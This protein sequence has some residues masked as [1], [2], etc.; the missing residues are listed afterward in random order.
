MLRPLKGHIPLLVLLL[1]VLLLTVL[2]AVLGQRSLKREAGLLLEVKRRQAD[3]LVRA[4][5]SASRLDMVFPDPEHRPLRDFLIDAG[6]AE[7]ILYAALYDGEGRFLLA[8]PGF[9]PDRQGMAPA[10]LS[11]F[12]GGQQRAERLYQEQGTGRVFVTVSR[13]APFDAPWVRLR[14]LGLPTV[15]GVTRGPETLAEA[16]RFR[17]ALIGMGT[18]DL[19]FS[20]REARRQVLLNGALLLLLGT[21]GFLFLILV[22][23][24]HAVRRALAQV[25][26]YSVDLVEGMSEGLV[27][28]DPGGVVRT[29]NPAA[30]R[31]LGI[32]AREAAGK[33]LR[34]LF[35]GEEWEELARAMTEG[36]S[37]FDREMSSP[38]TEGRPLSVSLSALKGEAGRGSVLFIRDLEMVRQLQ[39]EV[40]RSER[41][42]ALGRMVAGMAHEVR[43]P[44]NA[45]RGFTQHLSSRF[46]PGTSEARAAEVII[47]E[48]DRLNRV[49]TELLDFSRAK[50]VRKERLDLNDVARAAAALVE[51]EAAAA[52]VKLM[53][54]LTI[55]PL[56]VEAD[57]DS[58]K[59]VL[60]NLLLNGI[61]AMP[62][63]GILTV[64]TGMGEEGPAVTVSDT[65]PGIP[66]SDRERIFEPFFTTRARGT[67][68]GLALVHRI[69]QDHGGEVRVS[70]AEGKGSSFTVRLPRPSAPRKEGDA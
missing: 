63:G 69:V 18:A 21:V 44:L 59:Q 51:R 19:D 68:L 45:I 2:L 26:Q 64:G 35:P 6:G 29:V 31:L 32:T 55:A 54:D 52:G 41:L 14:L 40:R 28:A 37:W 8:S 25:R 34:A 60:L 47:R 67:G 20:L 5:T 3:L 48:V 46:S 16:D 4:L 17:Y 49:I 27:V 62:E 61:Q 7:G 13:F 56:P 36:R 22:Q 38:R 1:A 58:L 57:P 33:P 23:G 39:E 70:S 9:D 30:E 50:T 11:S 66:A 10:E 42:A 43:N 65:G 15:P 53:E 24:N 12:L